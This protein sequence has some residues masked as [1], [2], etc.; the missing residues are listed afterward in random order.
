MRRYRTAA[1]V[2]AAAGA[3]HAQSAVILVDGS[4]GDLQTAI[5][6][7]GEGDVLLVRGGPYDSLTIDG[8]GLAVVVDEGHEVMVDAALTVRNLAP[9]EAVL[10]QGLARAAS[11]AGHRIH[12]NQGS[13]WI[14][15]CKL[16]SV[17]EL[18]TGIHPTE[19]LWVEASAA[20]VLA[21]CHVSADGIFA[22]DVAALVSA[23]SS[24]AL[25]ECVV[26]GGTAAPGS[27]PIGLGGDGL[28]VG[29]GTAHL[30]DCSIKGGGGGSGGTAMVPGI[31][32]LVCKDGS[33]G[34]DGLV[35]AGAATV[36]EVA[37]TTLAGGVGGGADASL[38][39]SPG[40]PGSPSVV[41]G[42]SLVP[43]PCAGRELSVEPS[44]AAG[45]T[46]V[47]VTA[48][49]EPGDL[50]VVLLG[51]PLSA[52]P[53]LFCGVLAI[54]PKVHQVLGTAGAAGT[55]TLAFVA[56]PLPAGLGEDVRLQAAALSAAGEVVLGGAAAL[57]LY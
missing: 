18:Y 38:G 23:S 5:Q 29:G 50:A 34:G 42:G 28:R 52:L 43:S 24:L 56:P 46:T 8:K 41:L 57:T 49:G 21:R 31:G 22:T 15:D 55:A 54:A 14:E 39:C 35:I 19:T 20:V 44:P 11:S 4:G 12:D 7:A 6:A 10:I 47:T 48:V 1:L 51:E 27:G 13:V 40:P 3:A 32:A 45:G 37:S 2:A 53:A 17:G 26:L 25:Y 33:P 9:Q 16:T 30:A 36:V